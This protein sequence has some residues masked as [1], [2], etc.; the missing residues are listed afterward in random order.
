MSLDVVNEDETD[1]EA[2]YEVE[3]FSYNTH[4]LFFWGRNV[5]IYFLNEKL[6]SFNIRVSVIELIRLLLTLL[7]HIIDYVTIA[8]G[9]HLE[10]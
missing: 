2:N 4:F 7:L 8:L 5:T 10:S 3:S 6:V 9:P 1:N